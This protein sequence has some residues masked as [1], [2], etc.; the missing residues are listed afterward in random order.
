MTLLTESGMIVVA[1]LPAPMCD[2]LHTY[3]AGQDLYATWDP[4]EGGYLISLESFDFMLSAAGV[5][6]YNPRPS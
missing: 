2:W 6:A 4:E 5:S 3:L 1:S